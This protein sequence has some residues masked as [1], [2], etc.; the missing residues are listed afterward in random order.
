MN[1]SLK[2][3]AA[4]AAAAVVLP[5]STAMAMEY[6]LTTT[7]PISVPGDV[8]GTAIFA[9]FWE[10]PAGTGVFDPFLTLEREASGG[11]PS[12]Y[13]QAYNTDG[14]PLYLDQQRPHWNT[15]LQIGDLA[16]I[17]MGGINYFGFILD[18]NEPGQDK[19]LISIDNVRIYTS[20]TDNT[21]TVGDNLNKLDQL[22][23]LRWALNDPTKQNGKFNDEDWVKLDADQENVGYK[24]NGGSGQADMILYVPVDA[25]AGASDDDYLWFYNL[26]GVK[27]S[28]DSD[29]GAEAGYEEW[30][31]VLGRT[32]VP[33]GGSTLALFGLGLA[34]VGALKRRNRK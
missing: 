12:Y 31:A 25:F 15:L 20:A 14:A 17:D 27:Y 13:E 18:A 3:M 6:D 24:S 16:E 1:T 19:S 22:G 9:N 11:N 32:S 29:L 4:C 28:A 30:R 2:T 26:N 23:D 5:A 8:G 33:D 10:Q 7:S 34:A 21:A